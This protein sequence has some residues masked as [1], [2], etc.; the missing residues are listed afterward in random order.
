MP[1]APDAVQAAVLSRVDRKCR[2]TGSLTV[3]AIPAL[4]DVYMARFA[5]LFEVLGKGFTEPELADLRALVGPRLA[6]GFRQSPHAHFH[7]SWEPQ[8]APDHGVNYK[9]WLDIATVQEQYEHWAAT[10][11]PPLFGENADGKVL[12]AAARCSSP[13]DAPALDLG[14]G[15]GRNSLPLARAGH[16]TY[17]VELTHAFVTTIRDAA[18]GES[19]AVTVV[20][21]DVLRG[22]LFL[23]EDFF[24]LVA[25]SEVTSHFRGPEDLRTLFERA[26]RWLRPGGT[27][28]VNCFV[29]EDGHVLTELERQVAQVTWSMVFDRGELATACADL[30]LVLVAD[31][32]AHDFEQAHQ[33]TWPPTGWYADWARGYDLYK[34][35]PAPAPATMRWLT[36]R[37]LEPDPAP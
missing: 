37:R 8:G 10:K 2:S 34:L 25:C 18:A 5:A 7:L 1:F 22:E 27:F 6:D 16:P 30:P 36:F 33:P 20:E 19:L 26:A 21:G 23:P 17:A 35:K 3:P 28:V 29:A 32:D 31:E 4:L 15:T 9:V 24:A 11:T 12:A 13:P 14:A